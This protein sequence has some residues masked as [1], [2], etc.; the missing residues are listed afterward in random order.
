MSKKSL[1]CYL[2]QLPL[3]TCDTFFPIKS[4]EMQRFCAF[5]EG[6]SP[7]QDVGIPC[8]RFDFELGSSYLRPTMCLKYVLKNYFC[9]NSKIEN[10]FYTLGQNPTFF[11]KKS[12]EFDV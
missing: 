11:P 4:P 3:N 10:P 12:L 1:Y 5:Q 7:L 8:Y 9:D 6:L 2:E